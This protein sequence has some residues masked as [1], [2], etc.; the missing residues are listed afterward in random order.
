MED[1][2]L[3]EVPGGLK[4][5][6]EVLTTFSPRTGQR[7]S[8]EWQMPVETFLCLI[9]H[10]IPGRQAGALDSLHIWQL[11]KAFQLPYTRRVT[12]LP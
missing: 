6:G 11:D 7:P 3:R 12:H 1:R 9:V 5:A 8:F 10:K 4:V 2:D